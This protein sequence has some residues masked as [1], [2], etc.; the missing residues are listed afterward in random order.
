[1]MDRYSSDANSISDEISE[2]SVKLS[3]SAKVLDLLLSIVYRTDGAKS[4]LRG[5]G[6]D[7]LREAG[8]KYSVDMASGIC[9]VYM[10]CALS[11]LRP[12]CHSI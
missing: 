8:E 7:V 1:M 3:E 10:W 4:D 5:T 11:I 2:G 6:F 12:S 9:E